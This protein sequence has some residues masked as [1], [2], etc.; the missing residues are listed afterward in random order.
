MKTFKTSFPTQP[1]ERGSAFAVT[2]TATG[3][4]ILL[5]AA[6]GAAQA[7]TAD[8]SAPAAAPSAP[9]E[10]VTVTG[11]RRGIQDAIS[12]KR[13]SSSI[14]EAVSA[15]DIGK[16]P[17]SSIA[18][19]IARLPGIAAQRTNG[20]AQTMSI[21]GLGPD[22]TITTFN[23][24]EQ[25][26]TN[27]NRTIEFDQYPSELVS[28]VK[29]YKTPNAG[30]AYQGIAGTTDIE[31]V[32]PL[33]FGK[34]AMAATYR[35]EKDGMKAN[36]PSLPDSGDRAN[37]TYIDQ[38]RDNTVGVAF[39]VAF[40][41][42]AY[43]AQTREP[44][45]Y[46]DLPTPPYPAGSK[47]VGGDKDGFQS[48]YYERLGYLG[49]VELRP[50]DRLHMV[51]DGY[52]S[53]FKELQTKRRMEYGLQWS[54]ASLSTPGPFVGNRMVSGTYTNVP[55]LVVENYNNDRHAKLDSLGWNT[56]YQINDDWSVNG[57]LSWSK[58]DRDDLRVES[59]A[60]LG[61][62]PGLDPLLPPV[63]ETVTFNTDGDGVSTFT[64][65]HD[66]SDYN[67]TFLT[68]PGGWGGGKT[69]A[70]F[71]DNPTITDEVKA[72]KLAAERKLSESVFS[73]ASFGVNYAERTKS[74]YEWQSNLILRP[75]ASG[76]DVSH[77]VVPDAYRTGIT[78]TAFFGNPY[79][80]IGY[81]AIGLY[82]SGFFNTIDSRFNLA[83]NANDR[84]ASYYRTWDVTE[85]LTTPYVKLDIDSQLFGAALTGNIGVQAQRAD[86]SANITYVTGVDPITGFSI[87]TVVPQGAK[88]TEEDLKVVFKG[89]E[90]MET[91]PFSID[92]EGGSSGY[93][94]YKSKT[95]KT[96]GEWEIT[97]KYKDAVLATTK[98]TVGK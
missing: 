29:V 27:D 71:V 20:R 6:A 44:W 53:N 93:G 58:V 73:K 90:D 64:T 36:V 61:A 52:H 48:S 24:R 59:T 98:V 38:F 3:C 26:S 96:A 82:R 68:D 95:L 62:G 80:M 65:V 37:L 11:I 70:G 60:G 85:K 39:G 67:S 45:G 86:Q 25:A 89:G 66:Y 72:I 2:S 84:A 16:L 92:L 78:D 54:S 32:R 46:A 14:I 50:N 10:E 94:L 5:L 4:A 79:G 28:Q 22:F 33:A 34:R 8:Q 9:V 15:E 7:Q 23:G 49:V 1:V 55:F 17:D 97:V 30:M 19:S 18:E 88:Y 69:R 13:N 31:T 76:A 57:D 56:D 77:A 83:G 91:I 40:N 21:R 74:K 42:T 51:F 43:Q 35:R 81:D 47:I 87:A 75:D 12:A 63:P 41:K